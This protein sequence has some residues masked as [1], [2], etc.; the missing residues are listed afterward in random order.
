[1]AAQS[2]TIEFFERRPLQEFEVG[3]RKF[4]PL[5]VTNL[6]VDYDDGLWAV[7]LSPLDAVGSSQDFRAARQKLFE[8]IDFLW[9]EFVQCPEQELGETG[10]MQRELLLE[11]FSVS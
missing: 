11:L 7:S 10:K 8:Y 5:R 3:V 6:Q 4:V 1:M 9:N 2:S